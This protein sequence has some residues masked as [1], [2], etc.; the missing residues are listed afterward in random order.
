MSERWQKMITQ[1]LVML[2]WQTTRKEE[3]RTNQTRRETEE[4]TSDEC[5][6]SHKGVTE[7]RG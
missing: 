2:V 3:A 5:V 1:D 4:V 7:D 6:A